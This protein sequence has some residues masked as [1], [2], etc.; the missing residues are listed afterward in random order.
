MNEGTP[1]YNIASATALKSNR[2]TLFCFGVVH[3]RR[4][5]FYLHKEYSKRKLTPRREIK[6]MNTNSKKTTSKVVIVGLAC[7][8]TLI[9]NRIIP[10][11]PYIHVT[12]DFLPVFI[13]ALLYGPVW[14]GLCYGIAD[15][16]GSILIPYGPYNPIITICM[17]LTG[18]IMGLMF[19]KK[20]LSGKKLI[21]RST[22]T[23]FLVFIVR[24]FGTTFALWVYA[25][26]GDTYYA[27]IVARL[28]SCAISALLI[29]VL[30]PIAYKLLQ[31][32]LARMML[33]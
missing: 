13:V 17:I 14:A 12:F 24:I 1:R 31:K 8:I 26:V 9:L 20:D 19:Y 10:S 3:K 6:K 33:L 5:V 16:V 28:P 32:P 27:L 29:A 11:L 2:S 22:I 7:A 23:A 15:T 21:I 4:G 18:V 25:G 30:I